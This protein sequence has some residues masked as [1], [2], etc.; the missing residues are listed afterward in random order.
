MAIQ[1]YFLKGFFKLIE[2][3]FEIVDESKFSSLA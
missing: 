2:S 1:Q 3:N